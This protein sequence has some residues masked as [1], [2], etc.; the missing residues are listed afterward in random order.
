MDDDSAKNARSFETTRWSV[1]L[2][3]GHAS[4]PGRRSALE[5]LCRTYWMPVYAFIRKSGHD[6]HDAE[7]LTQAFLTRLIEKE[8]LSL[9]DPNRG[10]FRSFLLASVKNFLANEWRSRS[11]EKRGSN[12]VWIGFD[13]ADGE[14]HYMIEPVDKITPDQVFDR[15]WAISLIDRAVGDLGNEYRAAGK[16]RQFDVLKRFLTGD[17]P[18]GS[19]D[20]VAQ[21]LEI[22]MA[23]ATVAAHRLRRRY[24]EKL[25]NQISSTVA[26]PSEIDDEIRQLFRCVASQI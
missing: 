21:K 8:S 24:A 11:T 25:R 15:V 26:H 20:E 10:R 5:S 16:S 23:A 4:S 13:F 3:A 14:S 12:A 17:I 18:A 9:A 19:Y 2:Q 6:N 7:D 22:S 1:V